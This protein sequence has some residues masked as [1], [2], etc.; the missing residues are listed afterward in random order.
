M[1]FCLIPEATLPLLTHWIE[2]DKHHRGDSAEWWFTPGV[3][4]SVIED[5]VG[6]VCFVKLVKTD[7]GLTLHTQFGPQS[8]VSVRRLIPVILEA[9]PKIIEVAKPYGSL[10]FQSVSP[11]LISFMKRFGFEQSTESEDICVLNFPAIAGEVV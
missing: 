7:I 2:S 5:E 6:I 9:I 3:L 10:S 4:N 11:R 1:K 8:E